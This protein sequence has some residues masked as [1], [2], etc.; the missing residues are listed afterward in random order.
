M[1]VLLALNIVIAIIYFALV[2]LLSI[3]VHECGHATMAWLLGFHVSTVE[4]GPFQLKRNISEDGSGQWTLAV[5]RSGFL[6][7]IVHCR[8]SNIE[9]GGKGF[10]WAAVI[11]AGTFA[12]ALFG[13]FILIISL[14]TS[15]LAQELLGVVFIA[16]GMFVGANLFP[17]N[18]KRGRSDGLTL[19]KLAFDSRY[20]S[21]SIERMLFIERLKKFKADFAQQNLQGAAQ[22]LSLMR[23]ACFGAKSDILQRMVDHL[24]NHLDTG[25][26]ME[27]C[28]WS[29]SGASVAGIL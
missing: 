1:T 21:S 13:T 22:E 12:N 18:T 27:N 15:G 25:E 14:R 8:F 19:L 3:L 17:A 11:L 28:G 2:W 24:Q 7:G 23:T 4:V 26:S 5:L 20:R 9:T 16:A 29:P 10:R 6:S